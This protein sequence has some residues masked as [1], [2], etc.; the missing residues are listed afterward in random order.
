MQELMDP[1]K[2]ANELEENLV[3]KLKAWIL[4]DVK[5]LRKEIVSSFNS[6]AFD[7]LQDV[8]GEHLPKALQE[9]KTLKSMP[10]KLSAQGS[11]LQ[12]EILELK[13]T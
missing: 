9:N 10:G 7:I 4:V 12:K 1:D 2:G 11:T 8:L 13:N 6:A 3:N 5:G